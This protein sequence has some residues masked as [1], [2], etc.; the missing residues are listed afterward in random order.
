MPLSIWLKAG[1]L[2]L[3]IRTLRLHSMTS[4]AISLTNLDA[5]DAVVNDWETTK[6]ALVTLGAQHTVIQGSIDDLRR[7]LNTSESHV[8][9]ALSVLDEEAK[10]LL[11]KINT[12]DTDFKAIDAQLSDAYAG[13][14]ACLKDGLDRLRNIDRTTRV[15]RTMRGGVSTKGS[16][17]GMDEAQDGVDLSLID[18]VDATET[19]CPSHDLRLPPPT[20]SKAKNNVQSEETPAPYEKVFAPTVH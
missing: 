8:S 20:A 13:L 6:D 7:H 3:I 18:L 15:A 9:Q 5:L 17:V 12:T 11:T 16:W 10:S 1:S 4:F 19:K 14:R 2:K